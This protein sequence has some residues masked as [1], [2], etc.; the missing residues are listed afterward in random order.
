MSAVT[1]DT[2]DC[3]FCRMQKISNSTVEEGLRREGCQPSNTQ[4]HPAARVFRRFPII[5]D[6][7]EAF[8][9]RREVLMDIFPTSKLP[10]A[11]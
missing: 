11:T 5:V 2:H 1:R 9:R 4:N 8:V 3:G 6:T 7:L 10:N